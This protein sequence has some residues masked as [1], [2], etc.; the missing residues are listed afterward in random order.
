MKSMMQSDPPP[1][2]NERVNKQLEF[3]SCWGSFHL[4]TLSAYTHTI[5]GVAPSHEPVDLNPIVF[6]SLAL[7]IS[8]FTFCLFETESHTVAQAGLILMTYPNLALN[9]EQSCLSIQST[10]IIVVHHYTCLRLLYLKRL[11]V[12][13][14]VLK[15]NFIF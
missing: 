3:I 1:M 13:P 4:S 12:P 5:I 9:L 8:E 15:H 6:S 10:G 2:I 14:G 7:S 11:T